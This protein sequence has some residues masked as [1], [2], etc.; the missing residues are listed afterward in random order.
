MS[1][2]VLPI[3][4]FACLCGAVTASA[5]GDR[6]GDGLPDR[7]EK[8]YHLSPGKPS[9]KADPD[10]DHLSNRREYRLRTNPRNR[11]TDG[12]GSNDRIEV[13]NGPNPRAHSSHPGKRFPSPASTGVPAGWK[14]AR[15]R[16]TD[17]HVTQPGA[18]VHDLLL[19]NGDLFSTP[20]M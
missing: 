13:P 9:G 4:I 2:W 11:D 12:D 5:S 19:R 20:R 6:D 1:S 3:V 8:R 17:L 7:W 10:R 14:P 18:V 16:N 15:T